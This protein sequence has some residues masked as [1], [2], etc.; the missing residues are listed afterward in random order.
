M[1]VLTRLN[2]A[3]VAIN[4]EMIVFAEAN[5]DTLITLANGDRINVRES[6]EEVRKLFAQE[7]CDLIR[8]AGGFAVFATPAEAI[9]AAHREGDASPDDSRPRSDS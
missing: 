9:S 3:T 1:I 6:V 5:P 8:E 4:S 7:R 2:G